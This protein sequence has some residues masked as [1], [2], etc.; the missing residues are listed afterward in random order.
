MKKDKRG[1]IVTSHPSRLATGASN[2]W[3]HPKV[4]GFTSVGVQSVGALDAAIVHRLDRSV[5]E[6]GTNA[7]H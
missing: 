4:G 2:A 7:R 1:I 6:S 5:D 3:R